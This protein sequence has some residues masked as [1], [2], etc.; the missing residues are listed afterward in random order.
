V[1][2]VLL[3]QGNLAEARRSGVVLVPLDILRDLPLAQSR[4]DVSRVCAE[5]EQIR[6]AMLGDIVKATTGL[7]SIEVLVGGISLESFGRRVAS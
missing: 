4:D 2:N 5:N 1:G 3:E 6:S 7:R